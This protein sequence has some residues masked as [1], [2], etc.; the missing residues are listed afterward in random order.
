MGKGLF[1]HQSRPDMWT[2]S[3]E[4]RHDEDHANPDWTCGLRSKDGKWTCPP[5]EELKKQMH[6]RNAS[7]GQLHQKVGHHGRH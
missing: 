1:M 2:K 4:E 7:V 6:L 3:Q 5:S